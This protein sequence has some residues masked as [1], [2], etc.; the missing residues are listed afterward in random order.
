M[1]N[2]SDHGSPKKVVFGAPLIMGLSFWLFAFFFLSFCDGHKGH[3]EHAENDHTN[4]ATEQTSG[5]GEKEEGHDK[6]AAV[7]LMDTSAV[8]ADSLKAVEPHDAKPAEHH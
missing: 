4:A 6:Q 2:H 7:V 1:G 3:E 5:H 8:A